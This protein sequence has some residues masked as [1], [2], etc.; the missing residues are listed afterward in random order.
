M[1][2][3]VGDWVKADYNGQVV[4]GYVT[5]LHPDDMTC[6]ISVTQC[7]TNK[8]LKRLYLKFQEIITVN[9]VSFEPEDVG[10]LVDIALITGDKKWFHELV[11][12]FQAWKEQEKEL[13]T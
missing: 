7:D 13:N 12:R 9:F 1:Y 6:V 4:V 10:D 5:T 8:K 2:I 3:H 11:T